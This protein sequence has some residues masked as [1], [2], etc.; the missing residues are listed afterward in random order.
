MQRDL[1]SPDLLKW[2]NQNFAAFASTPIDFD[3][4]DHDFV[5]IEARI[6]ASLWDDKGDV[7]NSVASFMSAAHW[8]QAGIRLYHARQREPAYRLLKKAFAVREN[9]SW[10][11]RAEL[12]RY[13]G[14]SA[15]QNHKQADVDTCINLLSGDH[16]TRAM[17]PFLR[18]YQYERQ[19]QFYDAVREYE[20]AL[21]LNAGNDRRIERTYRPLIKCILSTNTPDYALAE[22]YALDW[23]KSSDTL[24]SKTALARTY[25]H[26]AEKDDGLNDDQREEIWNL[27]DGAL[28]AVRTHPGGWSDYCELQAEEFEIRE[29]YDKSME[30]L[31]KA[32]DPVTNQNPRFELRLKRWQVM[33]KSGEAAFAATAIA[34]LEKAK[35]DPQLKSNWNPFLEGLVECF[36]RATKIA[37]IKDANRINRFASPLSS[38]E[39]GRIIA[40]VNRELVFEQGDD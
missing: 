39:I 21:Q 13:F 4:G 33:T 27:Y 25:L 24:F 15:V 22:K 1:I 6:Q 35:N 9:F 14:L 17:A 29:A 3:A 18:G 38:R 10:S 12:T 2:R 20:K 19:R 37:G 8:F 32:I 16:R 23:R 34:E 31:D 7:P 11:S 40:G 36:V 5:R 26:W 28:D 30:W